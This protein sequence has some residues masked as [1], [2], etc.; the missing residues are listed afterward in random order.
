[1]NA[2]ID[3]T[4]EEQLKELVVYTATLLAQEE[5]DFAEK[6]QTLIANGQATQ[7]LSDLIGHS[8]KPHYADQ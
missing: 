8:T 3:L 5:P 1:M 2:F 4:G 7:V 6:C